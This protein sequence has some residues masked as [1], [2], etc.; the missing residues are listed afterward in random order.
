MVS[1]SWFANQDHAILLQSALLLNWPTLDLSEGES[2]LQQ[3]KALH[4]SNRVALNNSQSRQTHPPEFS[5]YLFCHLDY[6]L[7]HSCANW[8]VKTEIALK[9]LPILL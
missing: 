7:R 6:S 2:S 3:P 8:R 1:H 9:L 4:S 5:K